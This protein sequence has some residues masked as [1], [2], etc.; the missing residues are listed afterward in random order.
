[1]DGYKYESRDPRDMGYRS[2]YGS[3]QQN[4]YNS[5]S[6]SPIIGGGVVHKT[7]ING[8]AGMKRS[9]YE[10]NNNNRTSMSSAK[11]LTAEKSRSP[12]RVPTLQIGNRNEQK[13]FKS[14][15][16]S[17]Q[18][19]ILNNYINREEPSIYQNRHPRSS[20]KTPN[21]KALDYNS[22]I[23]N[24]ERKPSASKT[25][26]SIIKANLLKNYMNLKSQNQYPKPDTSY[27]SLDKSQ[28]QYNSVA[29]RGNSR[30]SNIDLNFSSL[31]DRRQKS[32]NMI[33]ESTMERKNLKESIM[34][35]YKDSSSKSKTKDSDTNKRSSLYQN[36]MNKRVSA[37]KDSREELKNWS[38]TD[39]SAWKQQT[40]LAK[41]TE[42]VDKL[43]NTS[44]SSAFKTDNS[45]NGMRKA[46]S[47]MIY[48][49]LDNE[50]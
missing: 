36:F 29:Q 50:K 42:L 6:R 49:S 19:K 18:P 5:R 1:M 4:N 27:N 14:A 47:G 16:A 22:S 26:T 9:L 39:S 48:H 8:G 30:S 17:N 20:K 15:I 40:A 24:Y 13:G 41:K 33:L 32:R 23:N 35:R 28:T 25:T 11:F 12:K 46:K 21:S 44:N 7:S 3:I 43:L 2:N 38:S 37:S 10:S 45:S 31:D 34:K